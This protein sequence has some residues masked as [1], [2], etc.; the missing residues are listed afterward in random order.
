MWDRC[1]REEAIVEEGTFQ[2][3]VDEGVE[4]VPD[5]DYA[6]LSRCGD[7]EEA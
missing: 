5:E 4:G 1:V 3:K 2:D 6:E 7:M